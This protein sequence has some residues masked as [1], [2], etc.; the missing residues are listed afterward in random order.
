MKTA[1]WLDIDDTT[2]REHAEMKKVYVIA[3]FIIQNAE[4]ADADYVHR[5]T[6]ICKG[7]ERLL[8]GDPE[9][10]MT[11]SSQLESVVS[12]EPEA[13]KVQQ[14]AATSAVNYGKPAA[15]ER[16]FNSVVRAFSYFF[17]CSSNIEEE[18]AQTL[19]I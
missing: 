14:M 13:L 1:K 18:T 7:L 8:D 3:N 17:P 15:T 11:E 12:E 5:L 10:A 19:R 2:S 6:P 9:V 4:P 16:F